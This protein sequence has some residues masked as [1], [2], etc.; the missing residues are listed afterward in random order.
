MT[1]PNWMHHSKKEKK[2]KRK[3]R[4]IQ[5]SKQQ[6]KHLKEKYGITG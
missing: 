3:V 6:L 4:L 1:T 5:Q 2:G